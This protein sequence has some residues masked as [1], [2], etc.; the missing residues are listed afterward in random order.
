MISEV[1]LG[2]LHRVSFSV[3]FLPGDNNCYLSGTFNCF[4]DGSIQMELRDGNWV[5]TLDLLPGKYRYY[6]EINQ[7][8]KVDHNRE[9]IRKPMELMLKQTGIYHDPG[10]SR[11]STSLPGIKVLRCI[12][13]PAIC[14]LKLV[15][16]SNSTIRPE[17][18]ARME[19]HNV[20][21]FI[22]QECNSYYFTSEDSRL[23]AGPFHCESGEPETSGS[24]IIYQVFPDRFSRSGPAGNFAPWDSIPD[25]RSLFGGNIRGIIEKLPYIKGLGVDH[26]YLNPFFTS[27]SNHRYDVDDY[28]QV[29]PV[30]GTN[31]DL[32]DLGK[33]LSKK[34]MHFIIDMVFNHTSVFF[35]V[36]RRSIDDGDKTAREWYCFIDGQSL[37]CSGNASKSL[38]DARALSYQ[39]FKEFPRMPKL[40]HGNEEVRKLMLRVMEYYSEI[41]PLSYMRYDVADSIDLGAMR[42]VLGHFR[43][44]YPK[45][46]HIAEI[47]CDPDIF[48][49]DGL[50]DSAIN[51][52]LRQIIIDLVRGKIGSR[53][54]NYELVK[55]RSHAPESALK[56]M[57]N[58]VGNHDT[59]RVSTLLGNKEA[60]LLSYALLFMFDGMPT[61]YYGDETGLVGGRDP[62]CRRTMPWDNLDLDLIEEFRKLADIRKKYDVMRNGY[63]KLARRKSGIFELTKVNG[64][65]S[66][67]M[68]FSIS[69]GE[70]HLNRIK[71]V[72]AHNVLEIGN[73]VIFSKYS[74]SIEVKACT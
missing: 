42:S 22:I 7:Y 53:K 54:F 43:K 50:Y 23:K 15:T 69:E 72:L 29:D 38:T 34:G 51:F 74:F 31:T 17:V 18:T 44:E 47:W 59:E 26:L 64:K 58:I 52:P 66:M 2:Y 13:E 10:D 61:I 48:T 35:P 57:M 16:G 9:I 68:R 24:N 49:R 25:S 30:L 21:E 46:G 19:T 70:I 62:D 73:S 37:N 63:V 36:F 1:D 5:A 67:T 12:T 4:G 45:I 65:E 6:F 14:D 28:F 11:L 33:E 20:F 41:L 27:Q 71:H 39:C 55:M 32:I 60:A 56:K 8:C 40:N 3:K